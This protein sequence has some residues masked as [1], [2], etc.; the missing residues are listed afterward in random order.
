MGHGRAPGVEHSGDADPGAEMLGIGGDG[1]QRFGRCL[2]QCIIDPRLVLVCDV[3]DRGRQGED[4]VE[5]GHG[6]EIGFSLRQPVPRGG[7][8]TLRAVAVAAGVVGDLAVAAVLTSRDVAAERRGPA[9]HDRRHHLELAEAHM[10]RIGPA[11]G[12]AVAIEDVGDLEPRAA[13][14][15][16]VRP[17]LAASPRRA[18][19][20]GRAGSSPRGSWWWRPGCRAPWCRAWRAPTGPGS[21]GCRCS[22]RA[23]GWRSCA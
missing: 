16:R 22:A 3:G 2:E 9:A 4:E 19:R 15:R 5:V 1:Q 17:P 18:T 13:H 23:G 6:Q 20:A 11:P 7:A 14:G 10:P 8:L 21:P 12:G